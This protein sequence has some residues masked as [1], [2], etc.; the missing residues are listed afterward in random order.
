MYN[1]RKSITELRKTLINCYSSIVNVHNYQY[2]FIC[3]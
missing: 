3:V 2:Y 1:K